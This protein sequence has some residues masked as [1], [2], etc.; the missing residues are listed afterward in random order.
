MIQN[1]QVKRLGRAHPLDA[2]FMQHPPHA[3]DGLSSIT[4][5]TEAM[6]NEFF[7]K[8]LLYMDHSN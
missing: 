1:L 3:S 8:V 7:T 2:Q 4:P 6:A 5:P